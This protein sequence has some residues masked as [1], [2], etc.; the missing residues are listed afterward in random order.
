MH[1]SLVGPLDHYH[2]HGGRN[3]A[4]MIELVAL[5]ALLGAFLATFSAIRSIVRRLGWESVLGGLRLRSQQRDGDDGDDDDAESM[6]E[7][8]G[9]GESEEE[10]RCCYRDEDGVATPE[11]EDKYLH[12][13]RVRCVLVGLAALIELGFGVAMTT[14]TMTKTSSSVLTAVQ[15]MRLGSSVCVS[16]ER[17]SDHRLTKDF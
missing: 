3:A 16:S 15:W 17:V 8:E 7:I 14:L 13:C 2:G 10:R 9:D 4:K 5:I 1:F 11:S 6:N 12:S